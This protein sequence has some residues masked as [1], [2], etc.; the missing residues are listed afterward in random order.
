MSWT[1]QESAVHVQV[2]RIQHQA[3]FFGPIIGALSLALAKDHM[4]NKK[5]HCTLNETPIVLPVI[6][7]FTSFAKSIITMLNCCANQDKV[8]LEFVHFL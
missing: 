2:M 6:S 8:D 1:S 7:D 5:E 4:V 3:G